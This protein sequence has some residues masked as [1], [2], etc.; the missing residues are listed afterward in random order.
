MVDRILRRLPD[1]ELA[2]DDPLPRF[3]GA[4]QEM[5]VRFTPAPASSS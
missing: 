5:P 3:I 1:L 4:I 2:V